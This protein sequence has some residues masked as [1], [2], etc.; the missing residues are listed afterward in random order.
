[1]L[2]KSSDLGLHEFS[3]GDG[4]HHTQ[5]LPRTL[6]VVA[7]VDVPHILI[8]L[9][10]MPRVVVSEDE[11]HILPPHILKALVSG[12]VRT[13]PPLHILKV[14]AFEGVHT[15]PLRTSRVEVSEDVHTLPLLH[16]SRVVIYEAVHTL[17]L[18]HTSKV[19]VSE[20]DHCTRT[21]TERA[22]AWEDESL[23]PLQSVD[24]HSPSTKTPS[25]E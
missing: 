4:D 22:G 23:L 7:A 16:T 17:P 6:K 25:L 21:H 18:L 24:L 3:E 10:H 12:D 14:L 8:L 13:L 20:D 1:M 15:L 19:E 2:K 9:P 11:H 5:P